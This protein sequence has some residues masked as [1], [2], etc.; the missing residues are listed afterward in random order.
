MKSFEIPEIPIHK[1][2]LWTLGVLVVI[3]CFWLLW[4][5]QEVLLLFLTAVILSTAV[6]PGVVWLEHKRVPK[7]AGTL[8]IFSLIFIFFITLIWYSLPVLSQQTT[9]ILQNLNEGYS[10]LRQ[11]LASF[12]NILWRRLIIVLP[13]DLP[14]IGGLTTASETTAVDAEQTA[15]NEQSS[16]AIKFL[17]QFV[18]LGILT[19]FWTLEE[20]RIKRGALLLVPIQ[21]RD[22]A[23]QL[24]Q[25]IEQKVSGYLM[26]QGLLVLIIGTLAF[27]AYTL[28]GLPNALL[29]AIF[30]GLFEAV[31]I[32]GPFLGAVPALAIALSISPATAIWV[33]IATAIIQQL[34]NSLLVP[35]VMDR[36][37]GVRPLVTLM[38]LLAFG[39][40]FGILGAL[41]AIPLAA[42]I[43]LLI[44]HF[45]VNSQDQE[46]VQ[47]GR[48][49]SSFLRYETREL[50][51][52]IRKF[53]RNKKDMPTAYADAYEDELEAIASDLE[54]F[55][56]GQGEESP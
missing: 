28:I 31:P 20:G 54:T 52:D 27:V 8:L 24:V 14:L 3:G 4:R 49:R 43:Q 16:L 33:I 13:Q 30:A 44:D 18:A 48:D 23:R 46:P 7:P 34:E 56:A 9:A 38:A 37:I 39:S 19:F 51:Q 21:K 11:N 2:I 32:I 50:V 41:I 15:G 55:L 10:S 22:N 47:A 29:L 12:P 40:L 53:I 42:V 1:L 5:F 45:L 26:G 17:V 6:R 35:R 25:E 36:T